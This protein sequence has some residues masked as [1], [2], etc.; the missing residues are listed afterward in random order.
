MELRAQY[1]VTWVR[2]GPVDPRA[3]W[4]TAIYAEVSRQIPTRLVPL[5]DLADPAIGHRLMAL[6][7]RLRERREWLTHIPTNMHSFLLRERARCPTVISCYDLGTRWTVDKLHL[8]NRVLVSAHRTKEELAT[9]TKLP[10]EPEVVYLA[11]PP[12]YKP[13]DVPRKRDQILFVG[14]EQ[15]RKNVDG[16]FRMVAKVRRTRPVTLVKVGKASPERESLM[17]LAREL[18]IHDH[19]VWRDFV[20][21]EELV[22][23]YQ[24]S[25]VAVVPSFLEGFSMPCLEAM[26]TGCPLIAS[27]LTVLPEIVGEGGL[28]LDPQDE[29]GWSDAILRILQDETFAGELGRRGI[30]RSH[31][32]SAAKSAE[33]TLRIYREVW[34]EWGRTE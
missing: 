5:V 18:G 33:Q 23:L 25:S 13:A 8:A 19:T 10:R 16:L 27:N 3:K 12:M 24:T 29:A 15:K 30:E 14:T 20:P 31:A 9:L 2:A 4:L 6:Q 22:S 32:F 17:R 34:E 11:V 7:W 28:L 26:S 21:E 1:P